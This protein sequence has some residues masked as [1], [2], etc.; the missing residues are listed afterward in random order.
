MLLNTWPIHELLGWLGDRCTNP[1]Y[2]LYITVIWIATPFSKV[3]CTSSYNCS[4]EKQTSERKVSRGKTCSAKILQLAIMTLKIWINDH[5]GWPEVI[6]FIIPR[7]FGFSG[8]EWWNV[9]KEWND[10]KLTI[11]LPFNTSS[12]IWMGTCW[13]GVLAQ[14]KTNYRYTQC[15]LF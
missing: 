7:A 10:Y 11:T 3:E 6:Y 14:H 13:Y 15:I 5:Q 4:Y 8:M 9:G 1:T 2:Y 12:Y